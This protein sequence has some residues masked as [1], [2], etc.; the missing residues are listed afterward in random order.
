MLPMATPLHPTPP[1]ADS[2]YDEELYVAL[3]EAPLVLVDAR[4]KGSAEH[5]GFGELA[6]IGEQK[7][8]GWGLAMTCRLRQVT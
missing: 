2:G 8:W 3:A 7:G 4:A 6:R 1:Q 5:A